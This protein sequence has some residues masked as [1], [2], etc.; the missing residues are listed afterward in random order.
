MSKKHLMKPI[1]IHSTNFTFID[2]TSPPYQTNKIPLMLGGVI[3]SNVKIT[4]K[5]INPV[6]PV[7]KTNPNSLAVKSNPLSQ[8]VEKF[9]SF[10][11]TVK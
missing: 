9:Q 10:Q 8:D 4:I 6:K 3:S 7:E 1:H 2:P 11:T 5:M